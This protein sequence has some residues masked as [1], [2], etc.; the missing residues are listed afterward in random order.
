MKFI[1]GLHNLK[2][3][4]AKSV[5]TIGN[6][7]GVHLGHQQLLQEVKRQ[8]ALLHAKSVVITFEPQPKEFFA[9]RPLVP[10][11]MRFA[12]KYLALQRVGIDYF[13]CLYFNEAL[14]TLSAKAFVEDILLKKLNLKAI[15]VG[16]DFRFGADRKGDFA[17]LQKLGKK[18]HFDA[19]EIPPFLFEKEP[20]SSTRIRAALCEGDM[21]LVQALLGQI[22]TLR[23][24][25]TYGHQ[26]GRDLGFPTANIDLHRELVPISGVFV[27]RA[28]LGGDVLNGVANVGIRP[29]FA[30]QRVLLEVHL[31]DFNRNIYGANLE[32][33]F[34]HKLREEKRYDSFDALLQQIKKDVSEAKKYFCAG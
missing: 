27:V 33:E 15:I 20:V 22:F 11:L 21:V 9:K 34:L 1:R 13:C 7:D 28:T 4:T 16:Y 23:G 12:E 26:R 14:A 3:F 18:Y 25:V 10:R 31:F 24:K 2:N 8:S 29:T 6:F 17:L 30:G 32:V 5:M 19:I